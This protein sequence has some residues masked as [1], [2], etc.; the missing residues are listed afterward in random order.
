[1]LPVLSTQDKGIPDSWVPWMEYASTVDSTL[2][3]YI[4]VKFNVAHHCYSR[5]N[6]ILCYNVLLIKSSVAKPMFFFIFTHNFFSQNHKVVRDT[7]CIL[8][9]FWHLKLC[10]II[11]YHSF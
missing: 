5:R 2:E 10:V 11:D 4:N 6:S 7:K 3:N 9:S 8:Y 1:M